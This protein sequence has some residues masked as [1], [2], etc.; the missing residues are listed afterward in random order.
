MFRQPW[1]QG[2]YRRMALGSLVLITLI[3]I[4][5]TCVFVSVFRVRNRNSDDMHQ[6]GITWSRAISYNIGRDLEATPHTDVA[7]RLFRLDATR[8]AFIIFR[9]G[10]TAGSPP[11]TMVRAMLLDFPALAATGPVPPVWERS[12]FCLSALRVRGQLVGVVGIRPLS[13]IQRSWP[14]VGAIG[15]VV[16]CG[17][18][19]LFTFAMVRPVRARL[20]ELQAAAKTFGQGDFRTRVTIDGSDEVAEVARAFNSMADEL[21]R[22]TTALETSDRLRRQLVADVSHELMTP[23]T[24]VLGHLETLDMEEVVLSDSERRRHMAIAMRE[25]SRLRRVIGDLVDSARH[26]AGGIQF[27][28]EEIST[29]ELFR[30]ITMRRE[31]ECRLRGI[32]L[33]MRVHTDAEVFEADPFRVE[34]AIENVVANAFRHTP[35]GGRIA[36]TAQ[37]VNDNIVFEV[38][39][40][41]EGIPSEHLP[42]IFDRFYKVSSAESIASPG[43]GLGLSIVKSIVTGHGGRVGATS[44][45]GIG[46]II[47]IELPVVASATKL[48]PVTTPA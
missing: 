47:S 34:Q 31:R 4:A 24:A 18:A 30:H 33:E 38:G 15:V 32:T 2:L 22:R 6:A 19:G 39:D 48:R 28:V 42:H 35:A 8:R 7:Q 46:T 43:S 9:D 26:E 45:P 25:A 3:V 36:V 10:R 37:R 20:I 17:A 40:S 41:G 12:S 5:E 1:H 21:E 14:L 16:L 23:L 29:A 11:D 13:V 27:R 44:A